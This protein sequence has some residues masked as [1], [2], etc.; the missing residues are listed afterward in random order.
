MCVFLTNARFR[1]RT[2]GVKRTSFHSSNVMKLECDIVLSTMIKNYVLSSKIIHTQ[3][4]I[5]FSTICFLVCTN[6][7]AWT[8]K[9]S[10]LLWQTKTRCNV[11]SPQFAGFS[12]LPPASPEACY[13]RFMRDPIFNKGLVVNLRFSGDELMPDGLTTII[14]IIITSLS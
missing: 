4:I 12:R 8:Q 9:G 11:A 5:N 6:I 2:R 14:I 3:N 13:V 10:E 1:A 7:D